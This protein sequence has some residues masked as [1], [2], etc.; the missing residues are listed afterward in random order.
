MRGESRAEELL[1]R[2]FE[3][4]GSTGSGSTEGPGSAVV[5]STPYL[6]LE[7]SLAGNRICK[8]R[9]STS[10]TKARALEP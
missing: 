6:E 4:S 8:L 7:H 9:I 3:G 2:C 5:Y 1:V 10:P